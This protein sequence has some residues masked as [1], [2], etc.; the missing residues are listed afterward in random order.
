MFF[1][2]SSEGSGS[3]F[4]TK[5]EAASRAA[6]RV[7]T[8]G[9]AGGSSDMAAAPACPV[10][11][12]AAGHSTPAPCTYGKVGKCYR[13]EALNNQPLRIVQKP[14]PLY[15]AQHIFLLKADFFSPP[16]ASLFLLITAHC[17]LDFCGMNW[18]PAEGRCSKCKCESREGVFVSQ[19]REAQWGGAPSPGQWQRQSYHKKFVS[20]WRCFSSKRLL[21]ISPSHI[22]LFLY[23]LL[24][25]KLW[26]LND[27]KLVSHK[28]LLIIGLQISTTAYLREELYI[29]VCGIPLLQNRQV[30][31][32]T[33]F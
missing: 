15:R 9:R 3:V 25:G 11:H 4:P 8:A 18:F 29:S 22:L 27:T 31:H 32:C 6:A 21:P 7:C 28:T 12:S 1:K 5:Q 33:V 26:L 30:L 16:T 24:D 20:F 23:W 17:E 13:N 10:Q 14:P 2:V 19:P